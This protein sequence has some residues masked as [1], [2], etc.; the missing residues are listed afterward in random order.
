MIDNDDMNKK[1]KQWEKLYQLYQRERESMKAGDSGSSGRRAVSQ[2]REG[3][4]VLDSLHSFPPLVVM[5]LAFKGS[6]GLLVISVQA[7][8]WWNVT[9]KIHPLSVYKVGLCDPP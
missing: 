3:D 5:A 8:R 9:D 7:P 6:T 2:T 4:L 1:E